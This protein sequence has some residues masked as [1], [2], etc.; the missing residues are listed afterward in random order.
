MDLPFVPLASVEK[1]NK[2]EIDMCI[3]IYIYKIEDAWMTL[4][5]ESI[6]LNVI[7]VVMVGGMST[8]FSFKMENSKALHF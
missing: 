1:D 3:N 8:M 7:F 5:R 6:C 4:Y 2:W